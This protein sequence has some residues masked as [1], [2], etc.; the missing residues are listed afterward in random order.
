MMAFFSTAGFLI[1]VLA[2]L[3]GLAII[4]LGLPGIWLIFGNAVVYSVITDYQRGRSDLRVLFVV[5]FLAVLAEIMEYGV[6]VIGARKLDVSRN[7]IIASLIGG[8]VGALIGFPIIIVGSLIGLFLGVFLGAFGYAFY[9][10]RDWRKAFNQALA[11]FFSRV[12]AMF[13]KTI[14]GLAMVLFLLV[15]SF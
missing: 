14:I 8:L 10:E 1:Y 2:L 15:K 7:T 3:V 4:P 9:V 5:L 11:A 12:A 6:S 13:L